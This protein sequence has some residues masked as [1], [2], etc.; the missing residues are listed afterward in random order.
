MTDLLAAA[1][2]ALKAPETIVKRS[3]EA[4][5]KATGASLDDVLAAWAGGGT[6]AA[7]APGAPASA[8][9]VAA[10]AAAPVAA[11]PPPMAAPVEEVVAVPAVAPA[12]APAVAV[13][14]RPAEEPVEA[15]PLGARLRLAGRIG[16]AA[17]LFVGLLVVVFAAQWLLPR[18]SVLGEEGATRPAVEVVPG[19]VVLGSGLLAAAVGVALAGLTRAAAG[20]GGPGMRLTGSWWATSAVGTLTGLAIGVLTGAVVT[21]AG[22]PVE[23]VEGITVVPV[24]A[25]TIWN[26]A[27]YVLAGWLIGLAVQAVGVPEGVPVAEAVDAGTV[28]RRLAT[29]FS[30]P[31]IGVVSILFLVLPMAFVFIEFPQ[32][33]PLL[34]L[35]VAGSILGFAGLSASRP[36]VRISRGEFAVAAAGIG[37]V[38]AIVAAVLATQGGGHGEDTPEEGVDAEAV[39]AVVL[40]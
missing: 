2:Q 29:A 14:E 10:P 16:A 32:W 5:A 39:A 21:G 12:P 35:F 23:G 26:V 28:R 40:V 36:G 4:R 13:L 22:S 33:A 11:V 20:W 17:G 18:A 34:A 38:V 19:W 37:V 27:G 1:A 9:P 25:A 7:S 15:A 8:A 31:L 3:A 6:V 30:T 24:V